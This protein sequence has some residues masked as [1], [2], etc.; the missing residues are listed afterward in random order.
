MIKMIGAESFNVEWMPSE[1][2]CYGCGNSFRIDDNNI[3]VFYKL[4]ID[5]SPFATRQQKP[6]SRNKHSVESIAFVADEDSLAFQKKMAESL[7][8]IAKN[9]EHERKYRIG[10][11]EKDKKNAELE[12]C[13]IKRYIINKWVALVFS[14]VGYISLS[15][16]IIEVYKKYGYDRISVF[17]TFGSSLMAFGF[18]YIIYSFFPKD[19]DLI[20]R[21]INNKR[22]KK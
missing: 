4:I 15:I 16:I 12:S 22:R 8:M 1:F 18:N 20:K 3:I 11:E 21:L 10:M 2:S 14:L 6:E 17:A 5:V 7:E 9:Q 19:I 13:A